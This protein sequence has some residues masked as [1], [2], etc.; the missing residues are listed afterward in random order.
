MLSQAFTSHSE[1]DFHSEIFHGVEV[2]ITAVFCEKVT[3]T[4]L[5]DQFFVD[6]FVEHG[7]ENFFAG[8]SYFLKMFPDIPD[9]FSWQMTAADILDI[10]SHHLFDSD[11]QL[12][13]HIMVF[14]SYR[15]NWFFGAMSSVWGWVVVFF[16]ISWMWFLW[17]MLLQMDL[18]I[19]F[20]ILRESGAEAREEV[21]WFELHVLYL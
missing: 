8:S 7:F 19:N 16:M 14:W 3:K 13:D 15:N 21:E 1:N 4:Y 11:D 2:F 9:D 5:L 20:I 18:S 10:F 12:F 6:V 17:L